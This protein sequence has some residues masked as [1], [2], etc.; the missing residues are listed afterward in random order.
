MDTTNAHQAEVERPYD[1]VATWDIIINFA[2]DG[3]D[4]PGTCRPAVFD[5]IPLTL[6]AWSYTVVI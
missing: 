3:S 5:P 4:S 2:F 6:I 1:H